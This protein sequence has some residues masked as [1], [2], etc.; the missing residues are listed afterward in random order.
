VLFAQASGVGIGALVAVQSRW[1]AD[2]GLA[3]GDGVLAALLSY[4][5]GLLL[6][7]GCLLFVPSAR[8]ALRSIPSLIRGRGLPWWALLGGIGGAVLIASQ[9]VTVPLLGVALF[10]VA[11]VAGQTASSLAVDRVGL[12]PG[13]KRAVTPTRLSGAVLA[14]VAVVVAVEPWRSD[15]RAV[16]AW[17]LGLAM[18]AGILVAMQQAVN[19]RVSARTSSPLAAGWINFA[20]GVVV[21][22]V[23]AA[24]RHGGGGAIPWDRWWLLLGGPIGAL[25]VV[26]T[27]SIVRLIGVLM[28]S[29]TII[30]GLLAGAIVV[31]SLVPSGRPLNAATYAG[32]ALTFIAVVLA[33]AR[34]RGPA[35]GTTTNPSSTSAGAA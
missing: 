33:S 7:T 21:L 4:V 28:V 30:S 11:V 18:F 3:L 23:I 22:L 17:A 13:D 25:Y 6:L 16:A 15:A 2:L 24:F 26:V 32:A 14:T 27:A 12:G 35:A 10:T 1:N 31:D 19:G 20:V 34:S 29:L 5:I 8:A 9:S